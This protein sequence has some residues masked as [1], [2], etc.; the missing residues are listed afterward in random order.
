[1]VCAES[2]EECQKFLELGADYISFEPP[3]LIGSTTE[4]VT[5]SQLDVVKKVLDI[6]GAEKLVIGAGIK[7]INDIKIAKKLWVAGVLIASAITCVDDP[8]DVL[9]Y[10]ASWMI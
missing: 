5:G 9:E 6:V 7:N 10:F 3:D 8:L 4:S 1:M 2:V